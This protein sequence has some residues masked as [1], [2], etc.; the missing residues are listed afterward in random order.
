MEKLIP[1]TLLNIIQ[2]VIIVIY[3]PINRDKQLYGR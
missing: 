2:I 3:V 1:L